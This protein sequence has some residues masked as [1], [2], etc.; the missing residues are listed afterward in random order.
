MMIVNGCAVYD[1][2]HVNYDRYYIPHQNHVYIYRHYYNNCY[3]KKY[4][5]RHYYYR[6]YRRNHCRRY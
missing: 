6:H 4:N 1:C 3:H 2:N 5:N